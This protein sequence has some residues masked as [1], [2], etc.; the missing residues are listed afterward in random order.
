MNMAKG[1]IVLQEDFWIIE[2][3]NVKQQ[4]EIMSAH[5]ISN[6]VTRIYRSN[7]F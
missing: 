2:I 3:F 4:N 1:E 5:W 6:G 7:E